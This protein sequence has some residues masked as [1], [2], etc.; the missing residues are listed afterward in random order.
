MDNQTVLST[1]AALS[2]SLIGGVATLAGTWI[3][4]HRHL[5]AQA[6]MQEVA[7]REALYSEFIVE[8][9]KRLADAWNHQAEGPEV[10]ATLYAALQRMRLT[11]TCEVVEAAKHVI[12]HVIDAYAAPTRTFQEAR[13]KVH[14]DELPDLLGEFSECCRRELSRVQRS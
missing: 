4:Q 2:G 7:K 6:R 12:R 9:S 8:A 1:A 3:S 10:V 11:S 13:E 5:R 14:K